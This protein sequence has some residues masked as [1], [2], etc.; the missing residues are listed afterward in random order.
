MTMIISRVCRFVATLGPV[1][2]LPIPGTMGTLCAIP[3]FILMRDYLGR[4][5]FF[6]ERLFVALF[7]LAAVWVINR[8]LVG[9]HEHDPSE[10]V[11]DEVL[12]FFVLMMDE[13]LSVPLIVIG[14]LYFRFFDIVKPLGIDRLE[15]IGGGWGIVLDDV[16]A[17][18]YARILLDITQYFFQF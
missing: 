5:P 9:M 8:A 12:G 14:F 17:A 13:R 15:S 6:D 18:I 11:L 2:Y 3:L 1:G 10:I 16:L 7:L 4:L